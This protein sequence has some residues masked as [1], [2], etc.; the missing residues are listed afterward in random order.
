[1][2]KNTS[3][4]SDYCKVGLYDILLGKAHEWSKHL[5]Q[6]LHTK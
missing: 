6:A 3:L 2:M 4:I 5:N 1:M